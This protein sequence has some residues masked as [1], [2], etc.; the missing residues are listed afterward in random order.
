MSPPG[1]RIGHGIKAI[2]V[3]ML[4]GLFLC[5]LLPAGPVQAVQAASET[6]F[7][8]SIST[9]GQTLSPQGQ[10]EPVPPNPLIYLDVWLFGGLVLLVALIVVVKYLWRALQP[11]DRDPS[12]GLQPWERPD[13]DDDQQ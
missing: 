10:G 11:D 3:A 7:S 9:A 12:D 13:Y 1:Q 8:P 6:A 2:P 5:S 4:L